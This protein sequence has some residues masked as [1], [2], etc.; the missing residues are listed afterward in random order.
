MNK[1]PILLLMSWAAVAVAEK[2]VLIYQLTGAIQC[3]EGTGTPPEQTADL[4][5]GQ[6]V[7]VVAA[8]ARPP[9]P[10]PIPL[11]W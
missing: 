8:A 3:T 4:L 9:A 7:K 11:L 10:N 1:I 5:R 2:P 6:G